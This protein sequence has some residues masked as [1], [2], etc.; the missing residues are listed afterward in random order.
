MTIC[1]VT[2][3]LRRPLIDFYWA[4]RLGF[5]FIGPLVIWWEPKA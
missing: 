2:F 3:M 4:P 1:G 5:V